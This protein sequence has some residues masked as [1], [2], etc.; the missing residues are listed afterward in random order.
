MRWDLEVDVVCLGS[1]LG[2]LSAAIVAHD[3]GA[4]V[5]IL[6]KAPK[7]GGVSAY[8]AG[9]VWLANNPKLREQGLEDSD[10]AGRRYLEFLAGGYAEPELRDA[11]LAHGREA[12]DYFAQRAGVR[13]HCLPGIPD[14]YY[15]RVESAHRGGRLL[16]VDLF[17]G[18]ELG[19][20][21]EKVLHSPHMPQGLTHADLQ[22][23]GG[24]AN[25]SGWD[26]ELLAQRIREDWRGTGPALA[27]SFVKAALVDRNVAAFLACP[28]RALVVEAGAVVGVEALREG[29][30]F[31]VGARRGVVIAV[32]GYDHDEALA[33]RYE[34]VPEWKSMCPPTVQGD[35]LVFA[36]EIGAAVAAVPPGDL[37][38]FLGYH[39]PGEEHAGVPLYRTA[40]ECGC[41]HTLVVNRRGERFCD[42]SFYRDYQPRLRR[43]DGHSQSLPN[44]PCFL[45]FDG[46]YRERLPMGT[47][48]PGVELPEGLAASAETPRALAAALGID[49]AGLEATLER[50][51]GFAREG[52]DRDFGRG[53]YGWSAGMVGDAKSKNPSL[54]VLEKPPWYGLRLSL[55][56][57]GINSHGLRTDR[58]ARVL[59]LRGHPIP[60]LYAAGNSAAL[61]DLG[62]GYQSGTSNL[63][64]LAWGLVAGRHAAGRG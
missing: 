33:R 60:G 45:I 58:F 51:N 50:F 49:A 12:I 18:A 64:G 26:Y 39:V 42:E 25:V 7:L 43:W 48:P 44:L 61:L 34:A 23:F 16:A 27:A 53:S 4:R 11:L 62:A 52:V 8:S 40:W 46:T 13:W 3:A 22:R 10:E 36:G 9:E 6:E 30:P 41:P 35:H 29:R 24:L 59:H 28:A 55:V 2:A 17:H 19:P 56:G 14:Y 63:R 5:A 57:A 32:G 31:R 15:P 37:A 1:G 21:Q 20:W 47:Y 54:G 38:M